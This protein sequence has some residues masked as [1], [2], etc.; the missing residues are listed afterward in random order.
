MK[1]WERKSI[2]D[3]TTDDDASDSL[4][5]ASSATPS[6]A[7]SILSTL[8]KQTGLSTASDILRNKRLSYNAQ[9][10][11]AAID[12]QILQHVLDSPL[13]AAA[14]TSSWYRETERALQCLI[15]SQRLVSGTAYKPEDLYKALCIRVRRR[16]QSAID[17]AEGCNQPNVLQHPPSPLHAHT[18][19]VTELKQALEIMEDDS[20]FPEVENTIARLL[21]TN[22]EWCPAVRRCLERTRREIYER[23]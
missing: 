23:P 13:T 1:D 19:E 16:I 14:V 4:K 8:W 18:R 21:E 7:H 6:A 10:H 22:A 5:P 20:K 17:E 2:T 3:Y 15:M 11:S 9:T 12:R